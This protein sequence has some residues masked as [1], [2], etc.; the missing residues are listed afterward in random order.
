MANNKKMSTDEFVRLAGREIG[1]FLATLPPAERKKRLKAARAI[2]TKTGGSRA[3][4]AH[5]VERPG[6]R[7]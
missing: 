5:S 2:V 6:L 7:P 1:S 3:T 4:T